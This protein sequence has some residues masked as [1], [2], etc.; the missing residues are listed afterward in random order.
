MRDLVMRYLSR[1]LSRRSFLK[2]MAAAGFTLTAAESV[3]SSLTPLAEAQTIA[4]EAVRIMEGT[5]GELLVQQLIAAGT[6]YFFYCN[7]SPAAPIL[8]ALV[9]TPEIK[10]I[11]GTSE[12]ITMALACGYSL[13][14]GQP[15]VVNVTTV[16]G[17]ASLMANLFNARRDYIPVVVTAGTHYSKGTGRD[18]F[19]DIDDILE[20]TKPFARWGF[21]ANYASRMP[22][23]TRMA[24]KMATTPPGGP[25]YLAC[26]RDILDQ[27][28]KGEIITRDRFDIPARVRPDNRA[29]EKAAKLLLEAKAPVL[30]V[31]HEVWRSGAI[32]QVIALAEMVG[33]PTVQVLSPYNDFPTTHSLYMG[34]V[35]GRFNIRHPKN[36]DAFL[37]LGG[38]M[39]YQQSDKPTIPREWKLIHASLDGESIGKVYPTDVALLGDVK[40]TTIALTEAIK[41]GL[42]PAL[43]AEVKKRNEETKA[44][45]DKLNESRMQFARRSWDNAPI[46]WGRL[47]YELNEG[48]DKEAVLVNEFG[49]SKDSVFRWFRCGSGEKSS[50]G[51][52]MGS[53]LGWSMGAALGIKLALP[54]RQVCCMVGDG[55]MMFGQFESLWTAARHDIPVIFVVFNNRSY[56]ETRLRHLS[57]GGK[58]AQQKKDLVN[59]LGNPDVAFA[60][61]AQAFGVKA[62]PVKT[63]DDLKNAIKRAVAATRDGKPYLLDVL[64]ERTGTL[65]ESTWYPK[66]S[67]AEMRQKKV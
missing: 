23:L 32:D 9:D 11:V 16:V 19:E 26:P 50:I 57:G 25:V 44:F 55:A 33:L 39:P 22:E 62:E 58:M 18:G 65:A 21:Q 36:V 27:K 41:Q 49:S 37:N 6:K 17:T 34:D 13:A 59:Y 30:G 7:S 56:N 64:V 66:V 63:P 61:A 54:D 60:D 48:L 14:T 4:P 20:I 15:S 42:T 47:G 1:D 28:A 46:S 45:T 5:G 35:A 8:D 10:I 51:R 67:V 3:L 52:T 31:G 2:G 12:N 29:V 24:F 53:A 38:R 40:E 43:K